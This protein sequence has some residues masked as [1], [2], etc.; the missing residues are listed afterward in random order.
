MPN[1]PDQKD[2]LTDI[3]ELQNDPGSARGEDF[4]VE[5]SNPDR[6]RYAT[7]D[8]G[9][10]PLTGHAAPRPNKPGK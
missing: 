6:D 1:R 2:K 10:S 4:T 9:K 7:K 3:A 5:N 8:K